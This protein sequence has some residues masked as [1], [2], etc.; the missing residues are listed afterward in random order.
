MQN[1]LYE[2]NNEFSRNKK[3]FESQDEARISIDLSGLSFS[4]SYFI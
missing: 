3:V 4:V 1:E 2:V